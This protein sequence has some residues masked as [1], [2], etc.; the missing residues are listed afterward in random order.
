MLLHELIF[1]HVSAS[2]DLAMVGR[3]GPGLSLWRRIGTP[4][5]AGYELVKTVT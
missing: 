1:F 3:G 4:A 5:Y 2:P